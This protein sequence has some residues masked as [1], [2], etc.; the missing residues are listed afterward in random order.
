ML[1]RSVVPKRYFGWHY[2][3]PVVH[4]PPEYAI[5]IAGSIRLTDPKDPKNKWGQHNLDMGGGHHNHLFGSY[6][7]NS[8]GPFESS[9][10]TTN[11]IPPVP[12]Y[13]DRIWCAGMAH[14]TN[15]NYHPKIYIKVPRGGAIVYCKWC[16][17]KYTNMATSDDNDDDWRGA[18]D[19]IAQTPETLAELRRPFRKWTGELFKSNF[20]DGKEPHRQLFRTAYNPQDHYYSKYFSGTFAKRATGK[21]DHVVENGTGAVA[22]PEAAARASVGGEARA[23]A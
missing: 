7:N 17:L 4:F 13:T 18:C 11:D 23:K 19:R 2:Q 6:D 20:Q 22:T 3:S 10:N 1:R 12:V 14:R 5:R 21:L 16:G 8:F 9:L 15:L